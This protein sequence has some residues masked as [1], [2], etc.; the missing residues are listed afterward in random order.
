MYAN[1][2]LYVYFICIKANQPWCQ[3]ASLLFGVRDALPGLGWDSLPCSK[4]FQ[5]FWDGEEAGKGDTPSPAL[6]SCS[7]A[8]LSMEGKN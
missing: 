3:K 4:P 7:N 8:C 2:H 5:L 1:T 6:Q